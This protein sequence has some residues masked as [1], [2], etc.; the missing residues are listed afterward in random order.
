VIVDSPPIMPVA[1]TRVLASLKLG[2]AIVAECD[3]TTM[4]AVGI[5][6]ESLVRAEARVIGVILNKAPTDSN[7]Y[8][9]YHADNSGSEK[10]GGS[11]VRILGRA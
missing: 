1:D 9:T 6:R 11:P 3:Q 2:V 10:S 5:A 4:K 8:Y 7:P